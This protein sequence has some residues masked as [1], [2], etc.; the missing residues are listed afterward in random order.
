MAHLIL[1]HSQQEMNLWGMSREYLK[2][3]IGLPFKKHYKSEIPEDSGRTLA[4][5]DQYL[6]QDNIKTQYDYE[7]IE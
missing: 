4:P 5:D 1:M 3:L 7:K 2:F 6:N